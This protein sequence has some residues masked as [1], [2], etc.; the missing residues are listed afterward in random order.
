MVAGRCGIEHDANGVRG[1][2]PR[3]SRSAGAWCEAVDA[4]ALD[5]IADQADIYLTALID[6]VPI[7]G[8]EVWTPVRH[9]LVAAVSTPLVRRMLTR[10]AAAHRPPTGFVRDLVIEASGEHRGTVDLKLGGISPLVELGRL[11]AVLSGSTQRA[12]LRRLEDAQAS[13]LISL[14]DRDDLTSALL[15]LTTVRLDHQCGQLADGRAP[16]DHLEPHELA[17]LT[18]RHL[19][20][21]LRVVARSQRQLASSPAGRV[22]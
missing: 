1:D 2:D 15:L 6:A 16:D 19:R 3:F 9:R 20:D 13:N 12:T 11:M 4:W 21:A 8:D 17:S 18:R 10:L 22:R 14:G 7:W 5:P